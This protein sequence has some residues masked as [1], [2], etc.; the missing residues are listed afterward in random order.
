MNHLGSNLTKVLSNIIDAIMSDVDK[1]VKQQ[2]EFLPKRAVKFGY[3]S[4]IWIEAPLHDNFSNND[5]RIKFNRA[6]NE[7]AQFHDDTFVLMLKKIW[8]PNDSSFYAAEY[9]RY[10]NE[11]YNTYWATIDATL[12]FADT[13][14]LKKKMTK[15][16]KTDYA[17]LSMQN[18]LQNFRLSRPLSRSKTPPHHSDD[19]YYKPRHFNHND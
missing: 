18:K 17:N 2:K 6:L 3:P 19:H 10:T 16:K 12:K 8:N 5:D 11:G 9:K 13:I 14:L 7:A 15:P 4:I 1:L